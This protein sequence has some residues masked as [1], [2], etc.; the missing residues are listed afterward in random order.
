MLHRYDIHGFAAFLAFRVFYFVKL[1]PA[2][3]VDRK[4]HNGWGIMLDD[5]LAGVW[6]A[7]ALVG[8][9][10]VCNRLFPGAGLFLGVF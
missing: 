7:V 4:I 3:W 9:D 5:L 8:I 1:P 2:S 10:M 6:A